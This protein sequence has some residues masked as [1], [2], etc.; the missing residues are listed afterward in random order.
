MCLSGYYLID[1]HE[2][3]GRESQGDM[4]NKSSHLARSPEARDYL[5]NVR[6]RVY[7]S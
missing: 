2:W 5:E 1:F 4:R 7:E 3:S 6:V